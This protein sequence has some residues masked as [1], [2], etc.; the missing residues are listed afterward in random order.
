MIT[1]VLE[2]IAKASP[3]GSGGD[4]P[5]DGVVV[6]GV[7]EVDDR[8][9]GRGGLGDRAGV[10]VGDDGRH[11]GDGDGDRLVVGVAGGVLDLDGEAVGGRGLEVEGRG[12]G[13]GDRAGVLVDGEGVAGVAGG[14]GPR[15]GVVVAGVGEVDDRRGGGGG[16]GDRAGVVVGDDG[17][18]VGHGDGDRLVVGV[19]GG[20]LDLDGEGVGGRGL[21]VE[22]R[23]GGHGDRAGVLVDRE[24]VAGVA[25]G[26]G[27]RDGVVVVAG[28]GEV[29]DRRGGGGGLGDRAGVVVSDDGRHVGDGDG[30]G[31]GV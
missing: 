17:R 16:L 9:G 19:A 15:D 28:V 18:H 12:G 25:G 4:G 6:A 3:V 22:G 30:D 5:C 21:E 14:D 10:V 11:V 2:S 7:G 1:P 27:P 26:D 8:R 13:H 29:D 31:L 20:V 23:G 24:G